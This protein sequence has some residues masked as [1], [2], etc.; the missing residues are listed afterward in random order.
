M[1]NLQH[2]VPQ[3]DPTGN[4]LASREEVIQEIEKFTKNNYEGTVKRIEKKIQRVL[5]KNDINGYQATDIVNEV[6]ADFIT[7]SGKND[8]KC[9]RNWDKNKHP[10]FEK[11]FIICCF[12][13][14]NNEFRKYLGSIKMDNS[15]KRGKKKLEKFEEFNDNDMDNIEVETLNDKFEKE[16]TQEELTDSTEDGEEVIDTD[17]DN[18]EE[19]TDTNGEINDQEYKDYDTE[20]H[21]FY[22]FSPNDYLQDKK[23]YENYIV[24]IN[25][26]FNEED[27]ENYLSKI[28]IKLEKSCPEALRV[29]DA[30]LEGVIKDMDLARELN[31]DIKKIRNIKKRIKRTEEKII[32]EFKNER[33]I[34]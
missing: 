9:I 11:Y 22:K 1:T 6:I 16:E 24:E 31:M 30:I 10:D 27:A 33:K 25:K 17:E 8:G 32:K 20:S 4:S 29:F 13:F 23:A 14:L 15:N 28:R 26:E 19:L 2:N 18:E 5:G 12:S 34:S 21:R 7:P 3:P